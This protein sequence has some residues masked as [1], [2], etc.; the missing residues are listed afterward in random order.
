DIIMQSTAE[1]VKTYCTRAG[2]DKLEGP[3]AEKVVE[4]LSSP[5]KSQSLGVLDMEHYPTLLDCLGYSTRKQV[6]LSLVT[7]VLENDMKLESVD[8]VNSLFKFI[9]PLVTDQP[10][11]PGNETKTAEFVSEQQQVCRLVHQ[12]CSGDPD[13]DFQMLTAARNFFGQGGQQRL[14]HSLPPVF[15]AATALV[16]RILEAERQRVES[17]VEG[18][19]PAVTV[20]KVFQF[21]HKTTTALMS[22]AAAPETALQLWLVAAAVTD[23]V[24]KNSGNPGFFESI[25]FEF[26]TQALIC[27]E[28]EIIESSKQFNGVFKLVG[29][30]QQLTCLEEENF[31]TVAA[32]IAQHAARLL[33]KP[34]QCRAVA[35]CSHLFWCDARRDGQKVLECMQKC[36]KIID[37]LVQSDRKQ[38][39]SPQSSPAKR[40]GG[41]R[42][43]LRHRPCSAEAL[44]RQALFW[45]ALFRRG[46]GLASAAGARARRPRGAPGFPAAA[47]APASA[48][49]GERK[50]IETWETEIQDKLDQCQQIVDTLK[51]AKIMKD[52]Q[53]EIVF[54]EVKYAR[55]EQATFCGR[56]YK[57]DK[58][59]SINVTMEAYVKS[60]DSSSSDSLFK[61]ELPVKPVK[62]KSRC[63]GSGRAPAFA[64]GCAALLAVAAAPGGRGGRRGGG[65][66]RAV[67]AARAAGGGTLEAL[68]SSCDNSWVRDLVQD[69][70]A[71]QHAPN[72]RSREVRSGHWVPLEPE[73]LGEPYLVATSAEMLR[74]LGLSEEEAGTER[75]AR[76][77]SG[78][79]SVVDGLQ[80]WATPYALSIYGHE[81]YQNCP[82][83]NGNGY[84]DGR[85]MSI[86]EFVGPDGQRWELQL[87]GAGR[88][89][90]CRGADGRA[91]LRSSVREFLVSEAMHHL[92]VPTTRAVSLVAS[93]SDTV[94]RPWYSAGRSVAADVSDADLDPTLRRL[95]QQQRG[96]DFDALDEEVKDQLREQLRSQMR[97]RGGGG[98][99]PDMMQQEA[100][101]IT[102]RAARSFLRIG[103][104]ELFARRARG[105]DP[106][107]LR[108]LELLLEHA[109][110]REYP[111]VEPGQPLQVRALGMLRAASRRISSL[112]AEWVRV[113][114]VQGNFNSDNCLVGGRT[115]DYGPFGFLE[116]YEPLWNMW[117]GGAEKYGFLNQPQAACKNFESL[118]AA[119]APILSDE[120]QGMVPEIVEEFKRLSAEAL[121]D[122]WRRKLGLD[123]PEEGAQLFASLEPLLRASGADW[124]LFWRSLAR[125]PGA[126][127]PDASDGE[128]GQVS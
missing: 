34:M 61:P 127:S 43:R 26:L 49:E 36:L 69:P 86:G 98:Q 16:P 106:G 33:K 27:F 17:G 91:V 120:Q 115:M 44:F 24:D 78:D 111:D 56:A 123:L 126:A 89:P 71:A 108:E 113:G 76:L 121:D 125:V 60:V 93:R 73:A 68:G 66:P 64:S 107:R 105:G 95:L 119:V 41:C 55:K 39:A 63:H 3:A 21:V 70:E 74:N 103:H 29:A 6:A 72:R 99:D 128:R 81:M 38:A 54:G 112:A 85:A 90:F 122:V 23:Q 110:A 118:A 1:L 48:P 18:N 7:G 40:A 97:Q 58:D 45:P 20:K 46:P 2:V 84:G 19:A 32:K 79:L 87:K 52:L 80:A 14:V 114:Y 51:G 62:V 5:L 53:K 88:T 100:C 42:T 102:C 96:L 22:S 77:F 9:A 116:R 117:V 101:A 4:L 15:Y 92:G 13:T 83:G 82:F 109:L 10:D 28:E 65:A 50:Q 35:A 30:L 8:T 31:D 124:T 75:F 67:A 11:T 57:Q 59:G 12:I 37:N 104:V 25:C 47:P 94:M